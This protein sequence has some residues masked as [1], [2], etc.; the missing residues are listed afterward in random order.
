ME[1][2]TNSRQIK[3]TNLLPFMNRI[4]F[5]LMF[6]KNKVR[7]VDIKIEYENFMPCK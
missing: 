6:E 1:S 2:E 5:E 7:V 3:I 4:F